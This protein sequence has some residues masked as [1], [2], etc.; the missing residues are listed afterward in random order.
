MT[1][2]TQALSHSPDSSERSAT[3]GEQRWQQ[4]Q[5]VAQP[6]STSGT[7]RAALVALRRLSL[8]I[9]LLLND[10]ELEDNAAAV[11]KPTQGLCSF[12][13]RE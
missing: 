6:L 8:D 3:P 10:R 4:Q 13:Q 11:A 12:Q 7:S 9:S 5:L 2:S 1:T